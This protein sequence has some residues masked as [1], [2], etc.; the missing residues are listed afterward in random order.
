M[1]SVKF[2]T[3]NHSEYGKLTVYADKEKNLQKKM[4]RLILRN[5]DIKEHNNK[6]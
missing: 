3:I 1:D 6:N 5:N 2:L 4:N